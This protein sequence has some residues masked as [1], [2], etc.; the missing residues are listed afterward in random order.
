M[1]CALSRGTSICRERWRALPLLLIAWLLASCC[2]SSGL[3]KANDARAAASTGGL[4]QIQPGTSRPT[5]A[6]TIRAT[7]PA[8][9]QKQISAASE[10]PCDPYSAPNTCYQTGSTCNVVILTCQRCCYDANGNAKGP[11]S[12]VCGACF[13]F[14]T[15]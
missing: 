6:P 13:G 5:V 15:P 10:R 3:L 2:S 1:M 14:S 12:C 8:T 11:S 9:D 4:G 7:A